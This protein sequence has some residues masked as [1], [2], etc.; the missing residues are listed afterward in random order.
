[1]R[2][3]LFILLYLKKLIK[4]GKVMS[5]GQHGSTDLLHIRDQDTREFFCQFQVL[6]SSSR[7]AHRDNP[8]SSPVSSKAR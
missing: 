6:T 5:R 2:D 7:K 1:M 3:E 4:N 8:K